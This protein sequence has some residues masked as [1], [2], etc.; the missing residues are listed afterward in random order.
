MMFVLVYIL[1]LRKRTIT[2][3]DMHT[4]YPPTDVQLVDESGSSSSES[5]IDTSSDID[6]SY[7]SSDSSDTSS[8]STSDETDTSTSEST[9][10]PSP[11]PS[12]TMSPT[13]EP[14]PFPAD[15][16]TSIS[17]C[18]MCAYALQKVDT[19]LQHMSGNVTQAK[20]KQVWNGLMDRLDSVDRMFL[21]ST[22]LLVKNVQGNTDIWFH[23]VGVDAET[24]TVPANLFR[25]QFGCLDDD[26]KG[27]YGIYTNKA[28]V[29][30]DWNREYH[31]MFRNEDD[32]QWVN[33]SNYND[34]TG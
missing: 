29:M 16:C 17:L 26:E 18:D 31:N 24:N 22:N 1:S 7:S 14:T 32:V 12:P 27:D 5:E 13:P 2:Q 33:F 8:L 23:K 15:Y 19:R 21:V 30:T 3:G 10:E 11:E 9:Y 25:R 20:L 34:S 6:T 28:Q 4:P